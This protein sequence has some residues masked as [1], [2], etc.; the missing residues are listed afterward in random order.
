MFVIVTI[1]VAAIVTYFAQMNQYKMICRER[2]KEVGDQLVALLMEDPQDFVDY[3]W[4]SKL[5]DI[6]QDDEEK[7]A[8]ITEVTAY[9]MGLIDHSDMVDEWGLGRST[10]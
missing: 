2:I 8:R 9:Y 7:G 3:A 6:M 1:T 4:D 5:T 10:H